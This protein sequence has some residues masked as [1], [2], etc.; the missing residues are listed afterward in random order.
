MKKAYQELALT[1]AALYLAASLEKWDLWPFIEGVCI[2][3]TIIL[4]MRFAITSWA[5]RGE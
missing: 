3:A 2:A 1:F 5:E 4:A